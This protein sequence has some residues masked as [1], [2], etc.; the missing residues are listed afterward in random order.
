MEAQ[1]RTRQVNRDRSERGEQSPRGAKQIVMPMT[2]QQ[3]DEIWSAAP[4]V[5]AFVDQVLLEFP[6]LFPAGMTEGYVLHGCDRASRKLEGVRL[7]KIVLS[8]GSSYWL[9]P[10][11]V[12]SGHNGSRSAAAAGEPRG[13]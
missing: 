4:R 3:Y 10:S 13:R 8:N 1:K 7:R 11:F 6:E 5:R 9:R 2:R 12:L